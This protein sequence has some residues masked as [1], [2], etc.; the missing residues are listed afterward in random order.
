MSDPLTQ[1]SSDL[2]LFGTTHA[3]AAVAAGVTP[4]RYEQILAH[5]REHGPS[6]LFEVAAALG[7]FEHQISGRFTE[8][9][10]QLLIERTGQTRPNPRSD[11]PCD[12]WRVC[13][14]P[15]HQGRQLPTTNS[16]LPTLLGYPDVLRI[17]ED[18]YDRDDSSPPEDGLPGVCYVRRADARGMRL[19]KRVE[20]VACPNCGKAMRLAEAPRT[21]ACSGGCGQRWDGAQVVSPGQPALLALILRP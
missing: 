21:Y 18:S 17:G 19:V 11:C 3:A 5:L 8:L 1:R 4:R 15:N 10:Q 9:S 6:T 20:L 14:P 13:D 16:Q 12:V 7:V 2:P